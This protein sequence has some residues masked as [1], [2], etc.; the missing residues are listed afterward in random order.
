MRSHTTYE[1]WHPMDT[2]EHLETAISRVADRYGLPQHRPE[3][4]Q[5]A[6]DAPNDA[7][8]CREPLNTMSG[9]LQPRFYISDYR[10]RYGKMGVTKY[11]NAPAMLATSE[12]VTW[13]VSA[14]MRKHSTPNSTLPTTGEINPFRR[15]RKSGRVPLVA[16]R[17]RVLTRDKHTCQYCGD[18]ADTV[19]HVI[20]F[21]HGGADSEANLVTA[22]S[23]CNQ[24]LSEK[25]FEDGVDGKRLYIAERLH[26]KK[27]WFRKSHSICG[28]CASLFRPEVDGASNLLCATCYKA[29]EEG[30]NGSLVAETKR[31]R[32]AVLKRMNRGWK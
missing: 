6:Q 16:L 31:E 13:K 32:S 4:P 25:Y 27:A 29:D 26:L 17:L 12:G 7:N 5:T 18:S 22:C 20:P 9:A 11:S 21:S 24:A 8:A 2:R 28:D 30:V 10:S 1:D 19:D 14:P 23:W 15:G 3:R